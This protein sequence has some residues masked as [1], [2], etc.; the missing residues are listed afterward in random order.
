MEL[1][2][3]GS[4]IILTCFLL[5]FM[6]VVVAADQKEV[7]FFEAI[8]QSAG[9]YRHSEGYDAEGH[10]IEAKADDEAWDLKVKLLQEKA[11]LQYTAKDFSAAGTKAGKN[12][13]YEEA[14]KNYNKAEEII[15]RTEK[16]EQLGEGNPEAELSRADDA[17]KNY[18]DQLEIEKMKSQIYRKW[19]GHEKEAAAAD[20]KVSALQEKVNFFI[21]KRMGPGYLGCLIAT[22]TFDSPM[23]PQVQ[24]LREFR[25]DNIYSTKSGTQFMTAFNA[26]YY[27]FSPTVAIFIDKHPSTKP[28]M[29]IILTPLLGILSLSKMS[30]FA[31]SFNSDLAV[32]VSGLVASTLIGMVYV[33]PVLF[34]LLVLIRRVYP[35]TFTTTVF[36]ILGGFAITGLVL[37]TFGGLISVNPVLLVGSVLFIVSL[38]LLTGLLLSWVCM[39]R[40][41]FW[42]QM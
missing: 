21:G 18:N 30:F 15:V 7:G 9:F 38:V 14:I 22:A 11:K 20:Q 34:V 27:S 23:A 17:E 4:Y 25:E 3:F 16:S 6:P 5:A 35:F 36:K 28:P 10:L 41:D 31:M 37:L 13:N 2:K 32:I 29:R 42:S 26:W 33:F 40:L 24:Q 1:H 39:N 19:P 12:G 8:E